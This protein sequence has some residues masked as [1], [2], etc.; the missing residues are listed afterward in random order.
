MK[1]T[2]HGSL[3]ALALVLTMTG[4]RPVAQGAAPE[5]FVSIFNGKDLTGWKIPEGDGGHWKVVD[6]V[7]DYD[8]GSQAQGQEPLDREVF[9]ELSVEDRLAHQGD[10]LHQQEHED[11]HARRTEQARRQRE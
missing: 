2:A 4:A 8:A 7:I 10:A 6:G 3:A 9:Q 1:T 11:R 5:G